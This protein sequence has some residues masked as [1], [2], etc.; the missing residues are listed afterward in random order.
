MIL[1]PV[2]NLFFVALI[3][4]DTDITNSIRQLR[5]IVC[6]ATTAASRRPS[7]HSNSEYRGSLSTMFSEPTSIANQNNVDIKSTT[8]QHHTRSHRCSSFLVLNEEDDEEN[9]SKVP[10]SSTRE[11]ES[12]ITCTILNMA[13]QNDINS[14]HM[15]CPTQ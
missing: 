6:T 1:W 14:H 9:L 7:P 4:Y 11:D 8:V 10:G 13:A 12:S 5:S 2:N 3:G 15:S